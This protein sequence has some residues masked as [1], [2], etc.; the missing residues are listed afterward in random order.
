MP[1]QTAARL[2]EW[3][4]ASHDPSNPFSVENTA[5]AA[6]S[7]AFEAADDDRPDDN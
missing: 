3:G 7:H 5:D 1:M 4:P 2:M 6:L